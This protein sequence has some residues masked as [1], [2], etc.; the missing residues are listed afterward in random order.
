M[1]L[2]FHLFTG[3]ILGFL[4]GDLLHD[5]RWIFPCAIGALL[6]DL[7]DKPLGHIIFASSIAY[8]RIYA[9]T[10]LFFLL[11]L[12]TGLI[13]WKVKRSPL[14][15]A[16]SVGVLSHTILDLMWREMENWSYPFLGPFRGKMPADYMLT[17]FNREL[18]NPAEVIL[19][20]VFCTGFILYIVS[21]RPGTDT[22]TFFKR[23][24]GV[25]KG[26]ALLLCILSCVFIGLA[27]MGI[28]LDFSGWT[29]PAEL[30]LVGVVAALAAFG[31]WRW[32]VS[33]GDS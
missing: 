2:F 23:L 24:R 15:L 32:Q 28:N 5:R 29:S 11:L 8:G 17:I 30:L 21:R 13:V 22:I 6:P 9:H 14:V 25:L 20:L 16:V 4:L 12:V 19:A 18:S 27:L 33:W 31:L 1:Y 10:L 26:G 7:I 3:L